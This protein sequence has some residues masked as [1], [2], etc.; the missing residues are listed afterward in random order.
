MQMCLDIKSE[1][2]KLSLK[3]VARAVEER[4]AEQTEASETVSYMTVKRCFAFARKMESEQVSDP[5]RV[6]TTK[7]SNASRWISRDKARA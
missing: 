5:Y 1:N 3:K 6:L 4:L 7:P 2:P